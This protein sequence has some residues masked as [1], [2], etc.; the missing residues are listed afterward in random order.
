MKRLPPVTSSS[1]ILVTVTLPTR[2][3]CIS[4]PSASRRK[5]SGAQGGCAI[6]IGEGV[7]AMPFDFSVSDVIP[8]SPQA[9]YDSWLDSQGHADITG[10][11]PAH[12]SALPGA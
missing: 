4:A 9:I 1:T 7:A 6:I 3:F 2:H 8:A 12:I 11:Q 10:R 5:L